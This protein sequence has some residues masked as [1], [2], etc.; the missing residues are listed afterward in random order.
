MLKIEI[1]SIKLPIFIWIESK[2]KSI[3]R[4]KSDKFRWQAIKGKFYC[5]ALR[6]SGRNFIQKQK[7]FFK[8][9]LDYKRTM[10]S[11]SRHRI[12][13]QLN[14]FSKWSLTTLPR[15]DWSMWTPSKTLSSLRGTTKMSRLFSFRGTN[16]KVHSRYKICAI[17]SK[18]LSFR[19]TTKAKRK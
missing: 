17:S 7:K 13:L 5:F 10:S 19:S 8:K 15:L 6:N 11:S 9:W 12:S 3:W 2:M 18:T 1:R 14:E 16:T 4:I